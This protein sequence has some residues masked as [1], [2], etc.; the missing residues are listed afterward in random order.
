MQ[1]KLLYFSFLAKLSTMASPKLIDLTF[2][3]TFTKGDQQKKKRYIEM[4]LKSTP[5]VIDE[6]FSDYQK[7]DFESVKRKAHSIKPQAQYMGIS[8]LKECLIKIESAVQNGNQSGQLSSL[9]EKAKELNQQAMLEL[10]QFL[11]KD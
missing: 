10:N 2:L 7:K 3:E 1:P 5:L 8:D 9:I 11:K 4:Y 6:L